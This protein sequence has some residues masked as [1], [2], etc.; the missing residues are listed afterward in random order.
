MWG[1]LCRCLSE[2]PINPTFI[3]QLAGDGRTKR[4][5]RVRRMALVPE[6]TATGP[7]QRKIHGQIRKSSIIMGVQ[8]SLI[9]QYSAAVYQRKQRTEDDV[10]MI[11]GRTSSQRQ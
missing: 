4:P 6:G 3:R 11:I 5:K 1:R 7:T 2:G 8:Q 9:V 10:E